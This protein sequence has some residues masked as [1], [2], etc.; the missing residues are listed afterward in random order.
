LCKNEKV[1]NEGVSEEVEKE[2]LVASEAK[3]F[4]N[5]L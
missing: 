2:E 1:E 4:I 5:V 3:W